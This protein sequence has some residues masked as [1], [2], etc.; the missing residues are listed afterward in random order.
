MDAVGLQH[1]HLVGNSMGAAVVLAVAVT[2]PDLV[3]RLVVMGATGVG[4]PLTPALD[5]LWGY[6]PSAENM[7]NLMPYFLDNQ[8]L[9]TEDLISMRYQASAR[10]GMQEAFASMFPAPRQQGVDDLAAY[11]DRL[12]E[13]QSPTLIIHGREDLIV[14][15]DNAERL[16]S[17]IDQAQLHLFGH[18]GH[19]TQIEHRDAFNRLVRDFLTE[20]AVAR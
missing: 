18:C 19:W 4:F 20:N 12:S 8:A 15:P 11:E 5:A 10:P 16:F 7:R 17:L 2:R 6:T 9:V 14:P 3:D 13:I 1:A